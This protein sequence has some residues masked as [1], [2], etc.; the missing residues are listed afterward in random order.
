MIKKFVL[1]N[2][3]KIRYNFGIWFIRKISPTLFNKVKPMLNCFCSE[4]PRPSILVMKEYYNDSNLKGVEIG[5]NQGLNAESILSELNVEKLYLIDPWEYKNI[6]HYKSLLKKY[7]HES[8][9]EIIKDFSMNVVERFDD[10]S[11]DFVYIDGAHDYDNVYKD[12]ENWTLKVKKGGFVAGHDIL[13]IMDVFNAVKD[14]CL[15]NRIFFRIKAPD[16]YFIK[17]EGL[18]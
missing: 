4:L 6:K 18:N 2:T 10:N 12:V 13:N 5:V 7:K 16:W 9:I 11:L 15:Q 1:K 17:G 14:Y 8:K 3:G